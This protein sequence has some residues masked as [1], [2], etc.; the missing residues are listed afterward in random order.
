MPSS[1]GDINIYKVSIGDLYNISKISVGEKV[2]YTAGNIV[3]YHVDTGVAYQEEADEGVSCLSPKSFT[4]AKAGWEFV[5]WRQDTS[6]GGNVLG[7][8][9][10]GDDPI[11]LY[12]VFRQSVTVTYYNGST[13]ASSTSGYRYYNN[14]NIVNPSFALNQAIMSGWAARGWSSSNSGNASIT[15]ANGATFTRD[16]NVTL[17]G[18]YQQTI[19][20]TY[21][22]NSTTASSA[23]GIRYWAPAGYINPSFTLSQAARSGWSARGW[24]TS[25][26][27]DG[28]ITYNNGAAFTRDSNVTLYGMYQ[29]TITVDYYNGSTNRSTTSG[30]RYYNSGSGNVVNPSFALTQA[31]L[32]GWTARGWSTS[33]AGNGGISYNNSVAFTRDS[34]ITLYGMYYQAITLTYYNASTTATSTSG[35][36]YYNPGSGSVVNPTF[37]LTPATLSGWTF[38]GWAASSDAAAG[39][40]YNSISNTA[41]SSNA[42]VYACYYQTI[43]LSYNGNGNTGGA[44]DSQ[45]GTRYYNTGNYSNPSFALRTNGFTR[46][47]YTFTKWALGSAGGTQYAAGTSITLAEN[48]TMYAVWE[49]SAYYAYQNGVAN[50]SMGITDPTIYLAEIKGDGGDMHDLAIVKYDNAIGV[51]AHIYC[52]EEEPW[53]P[54]F[55][56]Q[57]PDIPTNGL[58]NVSISMHS[59]NPISFGGE[60]TYYTQLY[61]INAGGG[62]TLLVDNMASLINGSFNVSGYKYIK[63]RMWVESGGGHSGLDSKDFIGIKDMRFF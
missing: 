5:G 25:S 57:T 41:F 36:R 45:T 9:V 37:S 59:A 33:T 52:D 1:A 10:M 2:V 58:P 53:G 20:V 43:T 54:T 15:Y 40:A 49:T 63:V 30:T 17:Y 12:A 35:T 38:R 47:S 3:T 48:T 8:L 11:T 56:A 46:T 13:T 29:Q 4:P 61:G 31:A 50:A 18:L 14:G 62:Q 28:G 60:V 7:S 6:A 23:S 32:S 19:T 26:A 51:I 39:I 27:G 22:N 16:S 21:Y 24:S 55:G 42:T 34:N 44:T